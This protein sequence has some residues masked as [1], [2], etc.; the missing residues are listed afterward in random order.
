MDRMI[1]ALVIVFTT[2]GLA[3]AANRTVCFELQLRDDRYDCADSSNVGERRACTSSY[4][5]LVGG[6]IELWDKDGVD[7]GGG[8]DEYIGTWVTTGT[9]EQ[10]ITFPWEGESYHKG[11]AHPD[12]YIK[13]KNEVR[14]TSGSGPI[15]R[16]VNDS[17]TKWGNWSWRSGDYTHTRVAV[18]C[19]TSGSCRILPGSALVPTT[20]AST[21]AS[22]MVQ[23]LD[24]AQHTLQVLSTIMDTTTID[25]E[26]PDSDSSCVSGCAIDR[27]NFGIPS[28]RGKDGDLVPHELGHLVQMQEFGKQ[29]A[30]DVLRVDCSKGT[31]GWS[32]TTDE[33]D[34]CATTEGFASYVAIVSMWDPGIPSVDPAYSGF[35]AAAA[36]PQQTTCSNNRGRPGQVIRAFWDLDD[37]GTGNNESSVSP[38]SGSD[39]TS[40]S[41]TWLVQRWD[42]FPDGTGDNEDYESGQHGVNMRDFM[43][44]GSTDTGTTLTHNCLQDQEDG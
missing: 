3:S 31:S 7:L 19:T 30:Q 37:S 12:L 33:H 42:L 11:E 27:Y 1:W 21:N 38:G 24:S 41:T 2:P 9:G 34:S 28:S 26:L 10:C 29:T 18:D 23:S 32:P 4:T 20:S 36:T 25:M 15:V 6:R 44:N 16:A 14:N 35:D 5:Y 40:L 39:D 8:A 22:M 17:G 13:Y 43:D